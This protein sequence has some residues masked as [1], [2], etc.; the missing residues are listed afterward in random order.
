M[1]TSV[2]TAAASQQ[3]LDDDSTTA[4]IKLGLSAPCLMQV[5][6][7]YNQAVVRIVPQQEF[8]K[9]FMTTYTALGTNGEFGASVDETLNKIREAACTIKDQIQEELLEL[10]SRLLDPSSVLDEGAAEL[11]LAQLYRAALTTSSDWLPLGAHQRHWPSIG[12]ENLMEGN[13]T[14]DP[15]TTVIAHTPPGRH[16]TVKAVRRHG[17]PDQGLRP[18]RH[19][20][21]VGK[22]VGFKRRRSQ[23][24]AQMQQA[25]QT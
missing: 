6:R 14:R 7:G 5:E 12:V 24:I 18:L 20:G 21:K 22:Q 23:R 25:K 2:F 8:V 11:S 4:E 10:E 13:A 16:E 17:I 19:E 3:R 9:R 1:S 15:A